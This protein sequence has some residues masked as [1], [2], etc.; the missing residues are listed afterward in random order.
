[1]AIIPSKTAPVSIPS[2]SDDAFRLL[3]QA[4]KVALAEQASAP[5]D[6]TVVRAECPRCGH[7]GTVKQSFGV[8]RVAS[9]EERAQSWCRRCRNSSASHPTRFGY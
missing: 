7:V 6:W 4:V 5:P 1:M 9:G 8:K 2:S 3:V